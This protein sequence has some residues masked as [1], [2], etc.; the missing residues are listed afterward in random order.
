[1]LPTQPD[2]KHMAMIAKMQKLSGIELDMMYV[3]E[4]GGKLTRAWRSFS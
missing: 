1:M 4:A 2:A 3:K